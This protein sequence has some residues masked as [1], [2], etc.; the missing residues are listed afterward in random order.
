MSKDELIAQAR[1][2]VVEGDEDAAVAVAEAV[3]AEGLDPLEIVT[4][5][6][7]KGMTEVGARFAAEDISLPE[8]IIAA[9]AMVA[10]MAVLEQH[11]PA[12]SRAQ[13]Q[14]TV[15]LGTAA[16]DMHDIGKRIVA[17][18][19]SVNGFEVVDLGRDVPVE[20]F[21]QE[22]AA[23]EADIVGCSA[24]MTS[25]MIGMQELENALRTAGLR[26]SVRTMIGG[27]A[28]TQH[29]A[30]KIGADAWAENANEALVKAKE[31]ALGSQTGAR[32]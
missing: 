32:G 4:E 13:K 2:A 29:W 25:T 8:V 18:M 26:E 24:L 15:V 19:L 9:D 28:T 6:F 17:T 12:E 16:G 5:G 3:V 30:D 10:G 21:V 27:A 22:A 7:T 31:L 14:G 20:R 11:I 23:N 1:R